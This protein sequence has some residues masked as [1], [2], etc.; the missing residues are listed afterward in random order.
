MADTPVVV[1]EFPEVGNYRVRVVKSSARGAAVADIR[2]FAK[3]PS[4]EGFTR[5]GIR[6]SSLAEVRL[7][8]E[9]LE[10]IEKDALL[11]E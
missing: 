2:E 6:L 9:A 3:G 10:A 1:R 5:R 7:L 11:K 4:F 8:R